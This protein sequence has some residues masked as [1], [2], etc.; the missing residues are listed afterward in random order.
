M[1]GRSYCI[2]YVGLLGVRMNEYRGAVW[3]LL[4]SHG[5]HASLCWSAGSWQTTESSQLHGQSEGTFGQLLPFLFPSISASQAAST[6]IAA[7]FVMCSKRPPGVLESLLAGICWNLSITS[8]PKVIYEMGA[9]LCGGND[10]GVWVQ[11]LPLPFP[12][13]LGQFAGHSDSQVPPSK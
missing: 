7:A 11:I 1:Q 8:L 3:W 4:L 5:G 2:V 9:V 6:V 13:T 12:V 10:C